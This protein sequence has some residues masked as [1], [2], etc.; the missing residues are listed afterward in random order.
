MHCSS[1]DALFI[2]R[3]TV[4]QQMH[5]SSADALFISR[6]TVHQQMHCSSADALFISRCTVHQQMHCS[7][8]DALFISRCTVHQQMHCSS[9]DALFISRCTV[10][11]Q[12]HCSSADAF[13]S[14]NSAVALFVLKRSAGSLVI[15]SAD[16]SNDIVSLYTYLKD[17]ATG[18]LSCDWFLF[19][20]TGAVH[21]AVS[22]Q[23][24]YLLILELVVCFVPFKRLAPTSFTRKPA[25][26]TVGGGRSSIRSTT[27]IKITP[28]I[29]TRR[30]DGF[31]NGR[32]L[33]VVMIEQ[34]RSRRRRHTVAARGGR[35][36][37]G[38][39]SETAGHYEW[40]ATAG[41]QCDCWTLRMECNC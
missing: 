28:S 11:Q 34:V 5:C 41:E 8:A 27:G 29:C 24:K 25:L 16:H 26:Q 36:A 22:A 9:A 31:W 13:H 14:D 18:F 17:L 6:C 12:M 35:R 7:S 32:K 33:L 39:G 21:A 30:S 15:P 10:H 2:S 4:H 38:R 3:C 23:L 20:A 40:N 37:C 1:A 19:V